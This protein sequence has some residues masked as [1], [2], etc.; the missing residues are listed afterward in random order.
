MGLDY[1]STSRLAPGS[2]GCLVG[3]LKIVLW[4]FKHTNTQIQ[5]HK[6]TNIAY[7][8]VPE[9]LNMFYIF[10]VNRRSTSDASH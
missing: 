10:S 3:W 5:I 9:I 1:C 7:N 2:P 6:Y 8:E 4:T